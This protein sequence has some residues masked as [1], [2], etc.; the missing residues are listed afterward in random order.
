MNKRLTRIALCCAFTAGAA[1]I[2]IGVATPGIFF[3]DAARA[4]V[5]PASAE[6]P[7][8]YVPD[9]L[10]AVS[11]VDGRSGYVAG[12]Y[13]TVL[14]T[15]DGGAR[16]QRQPMAQNDLIRRVRF[17]D[18]NTGFAVSHRGRILTTTN[19]G[20]SWTVLH[21]VQGV[22]LRDIAM[23]SRNDGWVVGHDQTILHTIDGG[24]SWTAQTFVK[25]T[26]DPPRLNG[27]AA[28]DAK[29]AI[30]VGEFGIIVRTDDGGATWRQLASPATTTLLAVAAAGDHAI[31]VGLNG[32]VVAIP[33]AGG[34]PRALALDA[35]APLLDVALDPAG[36]GFIVGGG[37][38]WEVS[39]ETLSRVKLDVPGGSDLVWLGG[40]GILPGGSAVA[41]GSRGLIVKFDPGSRSFRALPD[42]THPQGS[43][44]SAETASS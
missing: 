34:S 30:A 42:W 35:P 38:A 36:H 40:V 17:Q 28:F 23:V 2:A 1:G 24:R 20:K 11:F 8:R 19:G 29:T 12:Y 22:N 15:S 16:W 10:F 41:V 33:R 5:A 6:P 7:V 32:A 37:G 13:G 18:T 3:D 27:V 44:A 25:T 31:A 21:E 9:N 26:Q 14:R 4:A 43:N 39:G